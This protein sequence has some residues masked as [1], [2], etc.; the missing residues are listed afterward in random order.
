MI[1]Y[2]IDTFIVFEFV[3]S[4]ANCIIVVDFYFFF[5]VISLL[6]AILCRFVKE[7]YLR[8]FRVKLQLWICSK[9]VKTYARHCKENE[10][11]ICFLKIHF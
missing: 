10:T 6:R 1:T 2:A 9:G 7:S 8:P 3:N 11:E 5:L 4:F